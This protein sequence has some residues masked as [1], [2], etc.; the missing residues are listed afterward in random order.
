MASSAPPKAA[1]RAHTPVPP[2]KRPSGQFVAAAAPQARSES[3]PTATDP[4]IG[5]EITARLQLRI[6]DVIADVF[7][8]TQ[9]LLSDVDL[10]AEKVGETLLDLAMKVIPAEAGSFYVA[11]VNGHELAFLAVRGP[12]ADAIRR[13]GFTVPVGHGIVGFCAQEG[14][15]MLI[16]DIQ[17]DPRYFSAIADA[18]GY[19]PR[20]TLC[21]SAEKEGRLFGAIQ[22]INSRGGGFDP[23]QMEVLRY[24]GLTAADLLERV[25]N[26]T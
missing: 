2:P 26:A 5:R 20:D 8:A 14:I 15:C 13:A 7:D 18:I 9:M 17:N 25:A 3:S 1:V 6:D 4:Q 23:G 21:A 19:P 24:I 22:L 16:A 11:D 10:D 12:K